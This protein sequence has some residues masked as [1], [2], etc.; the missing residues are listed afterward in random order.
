MDSLKSLF[1]KKQYSL[2]IEITRDSIDDVSMFYRLSSLVALGKYQEALTLIEDHRD[3]YEKSLLALMRIHFEILAELKLF[4]KAYDEVKHYRDLPYVSQEVEEYL[5]AL[6]TIV[7]NAERH[8]SASADLSREKIE[9]VLTSS[10]DDYEILMILDYLKNQKLTPYI[11]LLLKL[12]SGGEHHPYVATF[13]LLLLVDSKYDKK[14]TIKKMDQSFAV[15]PS[16]LIPPYTGERYNRFTLEMGS[17]IKDPSLASCAINLFNEYIILSYPQEVLKDDNK[18]I[19]ATFMEIAREYLHSDEHILDPIFANL[20]LDRQE[21]I[22]NAKRIGE[23]LYSI[24][25]LKM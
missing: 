18:L 24:A 13:A 15:V 22:N 21:V 10:K 7:R 6:P 11:D 17:I 23:I 20:K 14:V 2:I 5:S 9:S 1:D 8:V 12:M 25:P 4:D 16:E 3:I 19:L